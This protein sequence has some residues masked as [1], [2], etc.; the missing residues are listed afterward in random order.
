MSRLTVLCSFQ[1]SCASRLQRKHTHT[2]T[3]ISC[4]SIHLIEHRCEAAALRRDGAC[5]EACPA[6]CVPLCRS[7]P[8]VVSARRV[9]SVSHTRMQECVGVGMARS[10]SGSSCPCTQ[11]NAHAHTHTHTLA[12]LPFKRSPQPLPRDW[13]VTPACSSHS[14]CISDSHSDRHIHSWR[15]QCTGNCHFER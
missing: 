8:V 13:R 11:T 15:W 1:S 2:H 10:A 3:H 9:W 12:T 14:I 4:V 7:R 5:D 6:S